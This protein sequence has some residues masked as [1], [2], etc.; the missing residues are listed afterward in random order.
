VPL[1]LPGHAAYVASKAAV[2][3]L[4]QGTARE[5]AELGITVNVV[6]ATPIATD[7]LRG[8]PEEKLEALIQSIPIKRFGT[9]ED[10]ANVVDFFLRPESHAV[11]GQVIA[12]GGV[13]IG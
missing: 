3:Y 12:L 8:V 4:S 1:R 9:H 5:V 7:M 10:V 6:A 2:Q 11:T 13:P